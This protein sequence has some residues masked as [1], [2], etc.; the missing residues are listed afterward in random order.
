MRRSILAFLIVLAL[1]I[2]APGLAW[3]G[4]KFRL[5]QGS[6]A[7]IAGK[8]LATYEMY[9]TLPFD[10]PPDL[11]QVV[12]DAIQATC[13]TPT[14]SQPPMVK[15]IYVDPNGQ[16]F[17]SSPVQASTGGYF[18]TTR[19]LPVTTDPVTYQVQL[20][21]D[22]NRVSVAGRTGDDRY[23]LFE[24]QVKLDPL[25]FTGTSSAMLALAGMALLLAGCLLLVH[26]RR[27]ARAG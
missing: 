11:D 1:V 5:K 19:R 24:V 26:E 27:L 7:R 15:V 23:N 18:L 4:H 3:A 2:G 13:L 17:P 25:A 10:M 6:G 8:S 9:G 16:S 22:G 12:I 14:P 21:C 20:R